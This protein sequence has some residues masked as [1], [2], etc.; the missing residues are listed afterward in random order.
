MVVALFFQIKI[1]KNSQKTAFFH[2]ELALSFNDVLALETF[3]QLEVYMD[4]VLPSDDSIY[5]VRLLADGDYWLLSNN[6]LK[7]QRKPMLYLRIGVDQNFFSFNMLKLAFLKN[8][9][10]RDACCLSDLQK[11][12]ILELKYK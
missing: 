2:P 10:N 8:L 3:D 6:K 4:S 5:Y 12:Q 9:N 11:V 7:T 1:A